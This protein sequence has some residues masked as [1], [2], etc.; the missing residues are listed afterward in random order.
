MTRLVD[1]INDIDEQ[2]V[3]SLDP[4]YVEWLDDFEQLPTQDDPHFYGYGFGEGDE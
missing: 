4:A 1:E 2:E 3:L